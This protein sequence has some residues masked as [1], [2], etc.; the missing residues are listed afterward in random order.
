M[1]NNFD[2]VIKTWLR[3]TF[4][5]IFI[6]YGALKLV[7]VS[8]VN[9]LL[10]DTFSFLDTSLV[11]Y[12]IGAFEVII[13]VGFLIKPLSRYVKVLFILQMFGTFAPILLAFDK[14]FQDDNILVLTSY[15]EFIF[16][17]LILIPVGFFLLTEEMYFK[18]DQL[19]E[20]S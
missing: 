12:M 11:I 5:L 2:I 7:G 9:P 18:T 4:A 17:N 19:Q 16:K 13:G 3:G 20:K 6:W 1:R 14:V 10:I 8:P 15:G